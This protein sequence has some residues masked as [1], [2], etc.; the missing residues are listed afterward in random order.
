MFT[1]PGE[2]AQSV[3]RD[4]ARDLPQIS[5]D[6]TASSVRAHGVGEA[7]RRACEESQLREAAEA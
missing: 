3:L 2:D 6:D 4:L 5:R 7:K 1:P